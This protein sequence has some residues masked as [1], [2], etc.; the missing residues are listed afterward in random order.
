MVAHVYYHTGERRHGT[1]APYA[2]RNKYGYEDQ[3]TTR[4]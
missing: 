2:S 4:D 3:V 1:L